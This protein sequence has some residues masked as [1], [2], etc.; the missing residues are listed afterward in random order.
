MAH[1]LPFFVAAIGLL[2]IA[3]AAQPAITQPTRTLSAAAADEFITVRLCPIS[4]VQKFDQPQNGA[5][6]FVF[7]Y[8]APD[9]GENASIYLATR[10]PVLTINGIGGEPVSPAVVERYEQMLLALRGAM[11]EHRALHVTADNATKEIRQIT[12][13]LSPL[14]ATAPG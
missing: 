7:I 14:C 5:V 6:Q 2:T 8:T 12:Y 13:D 11:S 3:E 1:K 4:E 9:I 10:G